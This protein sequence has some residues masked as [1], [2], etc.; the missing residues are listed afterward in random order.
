MPIRNYHKDNTMPEATDIDLPRL[1]RFSFGKLIV[2]KDV[3]KVLAMNRQSLS[4]L[5]RR[6]ADG[7][8]GN[9]TQDLRDRNDKAILEGFWIKSLYLLDE[10]CEVIGVRTNSSRTE[11]H[12]RVEY[13]EPQGLLR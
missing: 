1:P 4:L 11:T 9:V 3:H 12:V 10:G 6:H 2:D 5:L 8:W 13:D 7:D